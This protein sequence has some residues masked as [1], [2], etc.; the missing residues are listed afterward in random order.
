MTVRRI[1]KVI[2]AAAKTDGTDLEKAMAFYNYACKKYGLTKF[3]EGRQVKALVTEHE[4]GNSILPIVVIVASSVA[5]IT[6]IGV[7]I[8]LKRRKTLLAK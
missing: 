7:V 1:T 3:I 8:A 6:A 5:A 2:A 4:T